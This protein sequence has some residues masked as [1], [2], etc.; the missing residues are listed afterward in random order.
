[1][2]DEIKGEEVREQQWHPILVPN[3]K[4]LGMLALSPI[5]FNEMSHVFPILEVR[6]LR[7]SGHLGWP[8]LSRQLSKPCLSLTR[9]PWEGGALECPKEQQQQ[10]P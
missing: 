6:T 7:L 10:P 2:E 3:V 8:T 5:G 9:T 4:G 1:M